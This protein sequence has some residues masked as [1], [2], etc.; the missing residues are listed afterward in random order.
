MIWH[1]CF[2][3]YK[4]KAYDP[5]IES[6][7]IAG[8]AAVLLDESALRLAEMV[9][10]WIRVGFAQGNFNADNCLVGGHT[11]DYGPFGWME[12]Y[13]S[14]LCQMDGKWTTFWILESTHGRIGQLQCTCG[15]GCSS[16]LCRKR[17]RRLF[18]NAQ[19]YLDKAQEIFQAKLD[20]TFRVKLGLSKDNEGGD[21]L[22]R[23]LEPLL[24][25]TRVDWTIFWRQ[26][27]YVA[28]EFRQGS[29]DYEGMLEM[30]IG[31]G[32]SSP[33]YEPLSP[34]HRRQYLAWIEQWR[35]ILKDEE[36]GVAERMRAHESK[37][38]IERMDAGRCVLGC[39]RGRRKCTQGNV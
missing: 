12:E 23:S 35:D 27:S 31:H 34:E 13:S 26:L 20:E 39:C 17:Y 28:E 2:R 36:A 10:D 5:F 18:R 25:T 15:I 30:L 11:M 22:W 21:D 37:V 29:T 16:Y 38:C 4:Q 1:A 6:K 33:F 24:R 8:A 9:A 19:E 7:D 3:E 14:P 32:E